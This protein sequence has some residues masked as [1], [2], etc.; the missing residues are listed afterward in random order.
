MRAGVSKYKLRAG[1]VKYKFGAG[2]VKYKFGTEVVKYKLGPGTRARTGGQKHKYPVHIALC[3]FR[4]SPEVLVHH[5]Y[6]FATEKTHPFPMHS[7][8][9]LMFSG[10]RE[11]AH[12]ER[13]G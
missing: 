6:S 3:Y 8:S 2:T 13:M 10:D 7:Y 12:W 9:F 5:E 4:Q 11:R 1:T